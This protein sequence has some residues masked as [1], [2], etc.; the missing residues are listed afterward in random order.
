MRCGPLRRTL[1]VCSTCMYRPQVCYCSIVTSAK[2][3]S[4]ST[5]YSPLLRGWRWGDQRSSQSPLTRPVHPPCYCRRAAA[6]TA[7]YVRS[8]PHT[9]TCFF[10]CE[11]VSLGFIHTSL[12]RWPS[13][14]CLWAVE[15]GKT[16][17]PDRVR[18]RFT[19]RLYTSTCSRWTTAVR[20]KPLLFD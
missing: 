15:T 19:S 20:N 12:S 5:R 18:S 8:G 16:K 11:Q 10:N 9:H 1:C 7:A 13:G 2:G 4:N 14:T 6:N 17:M 3:S